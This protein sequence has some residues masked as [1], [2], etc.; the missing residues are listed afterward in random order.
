V[1]NNLVI[2]NQGGAISLPLPWERAQDNV[3]DGNV[4][5]G[6]GAVMDESTGPLRP[7]FQLNTS[8]AKQTVAQVCAHVAA[9]GANAPT[10]LD[11]GLELEDWRKASGQ[12]TGSTVVKLYHEYL[13][14]RALHFTFSVEESMLQA[15]AQSLPLDRILHAD[16]A[17]FF[18]HTLPAQ[19]ERMPGPF[20]AL[21]PG[22]HRVMLWPV[23]AR[24][25]QLQTKRSVGA[26]RTAR[27][28]FASVGL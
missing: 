23:R 24:V 27:Q 20:Q 1:I 13:S 6:G 25:D 22:Q 5:M 11:L 4:F 19:S 2:G 15:S 17:D 26:E 3:S 21:G 12:D 7:R 8:H 16:L 9:A 18:G 10:A 28:D 14:A